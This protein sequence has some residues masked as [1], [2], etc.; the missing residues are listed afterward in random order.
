MD[1]SQQSRRVLRLQTLAFTLLFLTVI[2]LLA[3]LSTRYVYQADWTGSGRHTLSTASTTLLERLDGPVTITAFSRD[4]DLSETRKRTREL[5]DRYR[6]HKPDISLSFI[7]PDQEPDKVR[8]LGVTVE[9]ELVINYQGRTE[10]LKTIGEQA[11]TNALQRLA[12]A[13]ERLLVFLGG[14]G[15]RNPDGIANHDI[16]QWANALRGKGF[17]THMLNLGL[18]PTIPENTAVLVI[19]SPQVELLPG[20]VEIIRGYIEKG[21]NLLL[22]SDPDESE[23]LLPIAEELG[24]DFLPGT[25]VDA[26]GKMLGIE[27]P[28]FVIVA[29]YPPHPVTDG[30]ETLTLFPLA[31]AVEPRD[32]S[33]KSIHLLRSLPRAWSETGPLEGEIRFDIE[34][35]IPGPLSIGVALERTIGGDAETHE[36]ESEEEHALHAHPMEL[37]A[38]PNQPM[39]RIAVLGD[40]DFLS[41]AYLGNGA[42]QALGDRLINWLSHDDS[43]I[44][45]PPRAAPD[46]RMEMSQSVSIIIGFGFLVVIPLALLGAGI[47]IWL[48]RR[49]R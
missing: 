11:L 9:G 25:L 31:H 19:A 23:N 28:G 4:E 38:S 30:L 42:N 43:F 14:H 8:D 33:W 15:E 35:D 18:N 48:K 3:W 26:T 36:G 27:H 13:G 40:G 46:T 10:N 34:S 17:Q 7:N 39:Q 16:N 2:G 6:Q 32:K 45:I 41:N 24:I 5:V 44:A 29:Q 1:I 20:E 12:R 49:K 47:T 22:L 21:G 37:N